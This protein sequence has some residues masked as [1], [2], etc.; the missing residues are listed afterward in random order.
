MLTPES[1]VHVPA[2]NSSITSVTFSGG[3]GIN[4]QLHAKRTDTAV[5]SVSVSDV[6]GATRKNRAPKISYKRL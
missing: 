2:A 6:T 5:T 3:G 4:D 1:T